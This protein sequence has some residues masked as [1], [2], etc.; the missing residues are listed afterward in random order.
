MVFSYSNIVK[1]SKLFAVLIRPFKFYIIRKVYKE[2]Y[3]KESFT[4]F[5]ATD[6]DTSF[7]EAF[8][9]REKK[10]EKLTVSDTHLLLITS[11]FK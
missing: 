10:G 3:F 1:S 9:E 5:K 8:I 2:I 11:V 6:T 4:S 7:K